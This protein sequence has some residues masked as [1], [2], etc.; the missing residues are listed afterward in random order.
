[1]S[2]SATASATR[3]V[4]ETSLNGDVTIRNDSLRIG[5]NLFF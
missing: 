2:T 5:F 1:M 4:P 3:P